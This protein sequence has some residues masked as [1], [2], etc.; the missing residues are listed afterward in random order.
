M[1]G[2]LNHVAIAVRDIGKAT[3]V[4]RDTLG[5][6]R[7]RGGAAA[8]PWRDHGVH[9]A[10]QYQDR[11]VGAARGRLADRQIPRAQSR[12]RHASHLLRGRRHPRCPRC[13]QSRR[14]RACSATAS[15]R[16]GR[17]ASRCCS[18]TRRISPALWSNSSR[19]MSVTTG[20]RDL[21]PDLV[22]G[23]VRSAAVGRAQ[24]ARGR[25]RCGAGRHRS[26]RADAFPRSAASCCGRRWSRP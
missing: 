18:C 15:R 9:H 23:A 16:S 24:P 6:E 14:A 7:F 21:L 8:R 19:L 11:A 22:G 1:I 5:A 13:A 2:R 26:R 25:A 20:D 10:A 17:M 12:R 4:Y 3:A